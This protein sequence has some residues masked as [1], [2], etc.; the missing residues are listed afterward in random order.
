M[1]AVACS[2]DGCTQPGTETVPFVLP[3]QADLLHARLL[4]A[5]L[6]MCRAH[7]QAV[8]EHRPVELVG[9]RHPRGQ[10]VWRVRMPGVA[11]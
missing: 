9:E 8:A 11:T 2:V 10:I 6:A 5:T 3:D 7:A 4:P 1:T